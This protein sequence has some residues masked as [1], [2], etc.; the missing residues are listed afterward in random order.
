[1]GVHFVKNSFQWVVCCLESSYCVPPP[2]AA[3][4]LRWQGI[5]SPACSFAHFATFY[6][7]CVRVLIHKAGQWKIFSGFDQTAP[8][9]S[10]LRNASLDLARELSKPLHPRPAVEYSPIFLSSIFLSRFPQQARSGT[11]KSEFEWALFSHY[12]ANDTVAILFLKN[13]NGHLIL[14]RRK[15][16]CPADWEP[17]ISLIQRQLARCGD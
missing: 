12:R 3:T 10:P 14:A 5:F 16:Q 15:L 8:G 2:R 17:F 7:I 13:S 1:M 9:E 4:K 11:A 6:T